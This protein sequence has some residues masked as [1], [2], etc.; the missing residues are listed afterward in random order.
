[1]KEFSR[2]FSQSFTVMG[3]TGHPGTHQAPTWQPPIDIYECSERI[4]IYVE[5]P[6]TEKEKLDVVVENGI[7]RISGYR[8]KQVPDEVEHIHQMEIPYGHFSRFVRLPEKTDVAS[9]NAKYENG[10][11]I[12]EIP[13]KGRK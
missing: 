11:L 2:F 8:P 5:L 10:F 1:M 13:R 9:I 12:I 4:C 3:T 6:G 7:L